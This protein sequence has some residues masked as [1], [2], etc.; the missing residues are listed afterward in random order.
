MLSFIAFTI[1]ILAALFLVPTRAQGSHRP[2]ESQNSPH[3]QE[4]CEPQNS[5][6]P[7][8]HHRENSPTQTLPSPR[9]L[10]MLMAANGIS[11]M[12]FSDN[13]E[14]LEIGSKALGIIGRAGDADFIE[15][16]RIQGKGENATCTQICWWEREDHKTHLLETKTVSYHALLSDGVNALEKNTCVTMTQANATDTLLADLAYHKTSRFL[17]IPIFFE[18]DLWGFLRLGLNERISPFIDYELDIFRSIGLFLVASLHRYRT[19]DALKASEDR[20]KD[21]TLATGEIVWELDA[22]GFFSYI[23]SRIHEVAG[24]SHEYLVGKRWEEISTEDYKD[25]T[26]QMF[27]AAITDKIIDDFEHAIVTK[28]GKTLWFHS[29]AI[30][31]IDSVGVAGLRGTSFNYTKT[32]ETAIKLDD[33]LQALQRSN[34][35]LEQAVEHAYNLAEKAHNANTAK[36][37][38]LANISHEIRTPLN[39]ISGMLYMLENTDPTPV[40][41]NY[42]TQ[43]K[44]ASAS[45][46]TIVDNI[47]NFTNIQT[48]TVESVLSDFNLADFL[49]ET[50]GLFTEK[51]AQK[52]LLSVFG[53]T[54][55]TPLHLRGDISSMRQ[56]V[57]NL[58]DNAIK[59]TD[60]GA[61][62]LTCSLVNQRD[63]SDI[64]LRFSVTDTGIG[65]PPDQQ[66]EML[67]AFTQKDASSTRRFGGTG[68]GLTIAH[69]LIHLNGGTFVLESTPNKGTNIHFTFAVQPSAD[70][71]QS[72][73]RTTFYQHLGVLVGDDSKDHFFISHMKKIGFYV[74]VVSLEELSDLPPKSP[75]NDSSLDPSG[76]PDISSTPHSPDAT[77]TPPSSDISNSADTPNISGAPTASHKT[78]NLNNLNSLDILAIPAP[79]LQKHPDELKTF[80]TANPYVI[81][82][83]LAITPQ[84]QCPTSFPDYITHCS[85][86]PLFTFLPPTPVNTDSSKAVSALSS[87][88][89][90]SKAQQQKALQ[91][92][93]IVIA[94]LED[95]DA[96]GRARFDELEPILSKV[97]ERNT[98]E[99]SHFL[100]MFQFA[101]A[102]PLLQ[103][104]K[105]KIIHNGH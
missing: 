14:S 40:Q 28:D 15:L 36:E 95:S 21:V 81:P 77:G 38:F 105:E 91:Q 65:I 83:V 33:T 74:D 31:L 89:K 72:Y 9:Q 69:Q 68:L 76:F 96:E 10:Q 101:E 20:F 51:L 7:Q 39:S 11:V 18:G 1:T 8:T 85:T 16:W 93:E 46:V 98:R 61:V 80:F 90:I 84:L 49:Q 56:I 64:V 62:G 58:L 59:F 29:A 42:I 6:A 43:I 71:Q 41:Q 66:E 24:Y 55:R 104:L 45:L 13:F 75:K 2:R 79:V 57:T 54:S 12:L 5:Q 60:K 32:R 94:L 30:L 78:D 82:M 53:I 102:V 27:E 63:S 23:S 97:D 87:E 37:N 19:Q 67:Q 35:E 73:T 50:A 26:S 70:E 4:S 100:V 44:D 17:F 3:F 103:T 92:L 34:L 25:V 52:H 99:V 88:G 86:G 47:L 22:N 48:G